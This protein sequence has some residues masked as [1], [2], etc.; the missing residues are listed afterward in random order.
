M[1]KLFVRVRVWRV[2]ARGQIDIVNFDALDDPRNGAGMPLPAQFGRFQFADGIARGNGNAVM[3]APLPVQSQ[4]RQAHRFEG[5]HGELVIEAFRFLKTDHIRFFYV[6]KGGNIRRAQTDRIDIPA[7]KRKGR[8]LLV[9]RQYGAG[10]NAF[11]SDG[12]REGR[13]ERARRYASYGQLNGPQSD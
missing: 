2:A 6:N 10:V 11:G 9:L 4:M 13:P 1:G 5:F 12:G 3:P 8:H 7:N